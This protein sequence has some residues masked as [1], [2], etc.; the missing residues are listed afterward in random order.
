MMDMGM[1]YGD[2]TKQGDRMHEKS[3]EDV[4][5]GGAAHIDCCGNRVLLIHK[6]EN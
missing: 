1:K 4:R 6:T 3:A 2:Y 5:T